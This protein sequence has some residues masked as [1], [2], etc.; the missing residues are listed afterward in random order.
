M[1]IWQLKNR[2]IFHKPWVRTLTVLGITMVAAVVLFPLVA[3]A[4]NT[5]DVAE[6]AA[7]YDEYDMPR[8]NMISYIGRLLGWMLVHG[9]S[10]LVG[11]IEEAVWEIGSLFQGFSTSEEAQALIDKVA[12]LG[13]TLFVFVLLYL[14]WQAMNNKVKWADLIQNAMLSLVVLLVLPVFMTQ[15]LTLTQQTMV[16]I[17]GDEGASI[18]DSLLST[19]VIDVTGYD[20]PGSFGS[21]GDVHPDQLFGGDGI[22]ITQMIDPDDCSDANAEIFNQYVD[23]GEL[24]EVDKAEIFGVKIEIFSTQYYRYKVN[25]LPIFVGLIISGVAFL[26]SGVKIAR[27]LYELAINQ[28]LAT[29]CAWLDVHSGQRLKKCL[30]TILATLLTL[31]GVYLCFAFYIIG[32]AWVAEWDIIPQMIAML[33]MAWALIDGPNLFEKIVGVDAGLQ[34][35]LRT[36]YGIRAAANMTRAVGRGI[37]GTRMMD[38][39]R[40]GG[41]INHTKNAASK[42]GNAAAVG[43]TVGGRVAGNIAGRIQGQKPVQQMEKSSGSPTSSAPA[44]SSAVSGGKGS[45]GSAPSASTQADTSSSPVLTNNAE[46]SAAAPVENQAE[47]SRPAEK[48]SDQIDRMEEASSASLENAKEAVDREQGDTRQQNRTNET[49]A[50]VTMGEYIRNRARNTGV[51]QTAQRIGANAK[52]G[53]Q[54]GKDLRQGKLQRKMDNALTP[55]GEQKLLQKNE[56]SVARYGRHQELEKRRQEVR[57]QRELQRGTNK[58]L[59]EAESANKWLD[60]HGGSVPKGGGDQ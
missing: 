24:K 49:N 40:V 60:K 13:A 4:L 27:L 50:P 21:N 54:D 57:T 42:A 7:L 56:R 14:A 19:N 11:M 35:G 25:W 39:S 59:R 33:A 47:D 32:Q 10:A 15:A 16:Y 18:T 46:N 30:Q 31:C 6:M 34:D 37:V 2:Q 22:S 51:V 45:D 36:M 3:V 53:Y 28:A 58:I 12:L 55:M 38:G 52:K 8:N 5:D 23:N 17:K 20:T 9:L 1:C 29:F 44:S 26:F 41:L 48:T 43:A